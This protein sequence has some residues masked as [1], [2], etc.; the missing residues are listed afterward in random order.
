MQVSHLIA[1]LCGV[2]LT[3]FIYQRL[4]L[5]RHNE[6]VT[7]SATVH[8]ENPKATPAKIFSALAEKDRSAEIASKE[9]MLAQLQ[10]ELQ[11]LRAQ[12]QAAEARIEAKEGK[13]QPWPAHIPDA[14]R[15]EQIEL[16]I[17]ELLAKT[18]LGSL[19]DIDCSEFPC[20]A[21][22]ESKKPGMEWDGQLQ[23]VIAQMAQAPEF[24]GKVALPMYGSISQD[25]DKQRQYAA[26]VLMP[27]EQF[28]D[29]VSR[30]VGSRAQ[31]ALAELMPGQPKR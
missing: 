24:G 12:N 8:S 13:V 20:V 6:P 4:I 30:R 22:I 17:T 18:G 7:G 2:V 31:G 21:V 29:D 16:R 9:Q 15:P 14:Y 5:P 1:A 26:V 27:Y 11:T 28:G 10:Q 3:I 19:A 23:K 25:G